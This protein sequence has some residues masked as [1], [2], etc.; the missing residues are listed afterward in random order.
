MPW[1]AIVRDRRGRF[2]LRES[3]RGV[4]VIQFAISNKGMDMRYSSSKELSEMRF[5]DQPT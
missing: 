2:G 5:E 4:L 1:M 3:L